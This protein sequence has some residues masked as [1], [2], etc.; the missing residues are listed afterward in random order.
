MSKSRSSVVVQLHFGM[1][2]LWWLHCNSTWTSTM[3]RS[4]KYLITKVYHSSSSHPTSKSL[5]YLFLCMYV[6][7]SLLVSAITILWESKSPNFSSIPSHSVKSNADKFSSYV[8]QSWKGKSPWYV[9][10]PVTRTSVPAF[11]FSLFFMSSGL[12]MICLF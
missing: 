5:L 9:T 11:I 8:M 2:E 12:V 6:C 10:V 3:M 1:P 7:Y 4:Q